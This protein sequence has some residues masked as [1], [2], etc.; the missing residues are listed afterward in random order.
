MAGTIFIILVCGA[1]V[2]LLAIVSSLFING[3]KMG[4]FF[5]KLFG[6][7]FKD[8][9][10]DEESV[11][12]VDVPAEDTVSSRTSISAKDINEG[13]N[14]WA[15][16][17]DVK[18][19]M[20]TLPEYINA[21]AAGMIM[22]LFPKEEHDPRTHGSVL[23]E[24]VIILLHMTDRAAFRHLESEESGK[25]IDQI[26][27]LTINETV[28]LLGKMGFMEDEVRP[29]LISR[30]DERQM[31]YGSLPVHITHDLL[32]QDDGS[33]FW[34]FVKNIATISKNE[35]NMKIPNE[36]LYISIMEMIIKL[37]IDELFERW[38]L[39]EKN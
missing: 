28:H 10:S 7:T 9:S 11:N 29:L 5:E 3:N 22:S 8:K 6:L 1:A 14:F 13:K 16:A 31:E 12:A 35:E 17:N 24:L 26:F 19:V 2:A 36:L 15:S 4:I 33:L 39:L 25:V 30:L 21:L 27:E 23:N 20:N 32:P 34:K 37:Q 18:Y 38:P